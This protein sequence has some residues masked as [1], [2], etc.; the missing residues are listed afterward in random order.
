[1]AVDAVEDSESVQIELKYDIIGAVED[2]AEIYSVDAGWL[3]KEAMWMLRNGLNLHLRPICEV[4]YVKPYQ[5]DGKT[6]GMQ[7]KV[8]RLGRKVA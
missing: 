5:K 1:M 6:V 4:R 7:A 3:A 8:Y 2:A